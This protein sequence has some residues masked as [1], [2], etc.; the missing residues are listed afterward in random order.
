VALPINTW[1]GD[2]Q[3]GLLSFLVS[4]L[5]CLP[6]LR[7]MSRMLTMTKGGFAWITTSLIKE[8][9][10][11]AILK[12]RAAERRKETG[13]E[14]W[15]CRYDEKIS[16][17]A[18]L[19]VNLSR[20]FIMTATEPILW[21]WDL[22]IAVIYGI[23]YLCFVAYPF[24]FTGIRGWSPG[25]TGL[26]FAGV[27]LGTSELYFIELRQLLLVLHDERQHIFTMSTVHHIAKFQSSFA[28]LHQHVKLT[29]FQ[30]Q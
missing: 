5:P 21:F 2:G 20:P 19:K 3:I 17:T 12:R 30:S 16:V 18:T 25:I 27:G 7:N 10:A 6:N 9:Y 1:A 29:Q 22:Y 28:I 8:T 26:S 15:W 4:A 13:D 24:I 11:P 14:R 23:L